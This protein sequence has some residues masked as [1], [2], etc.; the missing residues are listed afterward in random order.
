MKEQPD[1]RGWKIGSTMLAIHVIG[2]AHG[3]HLFGLVIVIQ[4]FAQTSG[5]EGNKLRDFLARNPT[6]VLSNTK[7]VGPAPYASGVD[8]RWR[9]H[10]KRLQVTCQLFQPVVHLDKGFGILG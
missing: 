2:K 1:G 5:Q 6:E 10:E 3:L 9:L 4:K 7:Q 8:L